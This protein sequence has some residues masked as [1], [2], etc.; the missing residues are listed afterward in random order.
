[1]ND[2][3]ADDLK[4]SIAAMEGIAKSCGLCLLENPGDM[5]MMIMRGAAGKLLKKLR[6]ELAQ[7][8][9]EVAS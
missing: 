2:K 8:E 6:A 4:K 7:L 1:M 9:K 3:T 5:S